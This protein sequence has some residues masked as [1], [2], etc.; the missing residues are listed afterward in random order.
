MSRTFS[1]QGQPSSG[2]DWPERLCSCHPWRFS[3]TA[4]A[5]WSDPIGDPALR[6]SLG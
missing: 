4:W 5:T 1:L 3:T 6:T 2:T